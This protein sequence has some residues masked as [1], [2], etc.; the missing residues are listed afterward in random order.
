[1]RTVSRYSVLQYKNQHASVADIAQQQNVRYILEGS[2]RK[3]SNSIRVSAELIDSQDGKICWSERYDRDLDDLFAVQ[4]E[5]TQK[6]TLAMKVQLD[7]GEMARHRSAGTGNIKAW[8]L[9]MT[10][11]D[12]TDT[13]IRQNILEARAMAKQALALDPEYAMAHVMLAW[14]FWQEVYSGWSKDQERSLAEAEQHS[15]QA[16]QL[17]PDNADALAQAGTGFIMRHDVERA[18]DYSGRAVKLEPG[19]AEN[20]A[21]LAFAHVFA[22]NYDQARVHEQNTRRLCPIM[23]NWYYLILGQ[24]E[25]L[26]GDLDKAIAIYRRALAVEVDS[27]LCRFYLVHALTRKGDLAAAQTLANEIR[28]LDSSVNGSG[29]VRA[30]SQDAELRNQFHRH[31]QQFDLV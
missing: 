23:P 6:I 10:S 25:Q 2:V 14:T 3:S 7:D 17:D 24:I 20:Q 28:E 12:L 18:L 8:E 4:D 16:L 21:L 29:L 26:S 22:G 1:M 27:P 15:R 13:Y 11:I 19:N 9:V 5:I 31:L 30:Y